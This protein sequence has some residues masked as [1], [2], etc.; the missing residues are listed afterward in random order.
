MK[1][2]NCSAKL[3]PGTTECEFCG[4]RITS[5]TDFLA[6]NKIP[7]MPS[8]S[9]ATSAPPGPPLQ[10]ATVVMSPLPESAV[11]Q[12]SPSPSENP[13]QHQSEAS[14]KN[15]IPNHMLWAV[16]ST[17]AATFFSICTCCFIPLGLPSGIAAITFANKVNTLLAMGDVEGAKEASKKAKLWSWVTTALAI[18]FSVWFA[19]SMLLNIFAVTN[20]N[21]NI[22]EEIR[23]EMEPNR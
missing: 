12:P 1:C 8:V 7:S 10:S 21:K 16:I 20:G 14:Y 19:L 23:S 4:H 11:P 2:P 13:Y 15:E 9:A 3:A 17:V 5:V 6:Q 18:I 22:F